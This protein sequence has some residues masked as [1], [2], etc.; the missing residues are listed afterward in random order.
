MFFPWYSKALGHTEARAST[1]VQLKTAKD[2]LNYV[3][4]YWSTPLRK[5]IMSRW[6]NKSSKQ[7]AAC[8]KK[9]EPTLYEK[10]WCTLEA[11]TSA[12][13][14][15]TQTDAS[16][17]RT[18]FLVDYL[19]VDGLKSDPMKLLGMIHNRVTYTPEQWALYDYQ[20]THYAWVGK[21]DIQYCEL[22]MIMHG[23]EYGSLVDWNEQ[24]AHRSEMIG[25]PRAQLVLEAQQFLSRFLRNVVEQLVGDLDATSSKDDTDELPQPQPQSL[26]RVE[27]WSVYTHQPFSP[28]PKFDILM[29]IDKATAQL[30][31]SAERLWLLQTSPEYLRESIRLMQNGLSDGIPK[32]AALNFVAKTIT[33]DI[34]NYW[35]WKAIFEGCENLRDM[36]KTED[37]RGNQICPGNPLPTEYE[38]A[39]HELQ[40]NLIFRIEAHR[41]ILLKTLSLRPQ[42]RGNFKQSYNSES[43]TLETIGKLKLGG[44]LERAPVL[45][46]LQTLASGLV[47]DG[48]PQWDHVERATRFAFLDECLV[49][50]PKQASLLDPDLY[51]DYTSHGVAQ[52]LR[53]NLDLHMPAPTHVQEEIRVFI[54]D[55]IPQSGNCSSFQFSS[56]LYKSTHR[57]YCLV[58]FSANCHNSMTLEFL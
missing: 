45:Y 20:R 51:D 24:A 57:I 19:N 12:T 38:E 4:T 32:L 14:V 42:F 8:L 10:Q 52:E 6:K 41:K 44:V 54:R 25:F 33:L 35:S 47:Q 30:E 53:F 31:M 23:P 9:A 17:F 55:M 50:N 16:N 46:A 3:R 11:N 26:G 15:Q 2:D 13:M 37:T 39:F 43:K 56:I 49:K 22:G 5:D 27:S 29:I 7:R 36:H 34:W 1:S 21:V 18:P 40:L 48:V 58:A 28:P